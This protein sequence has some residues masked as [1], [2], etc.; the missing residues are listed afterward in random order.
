MVF[1]GF[2]F[3]AGFG[4][5]M[6]LG[7]PTW[8]PHPIRWIGRLIAWEENV[9]RRIFPKN[10]QGALWAGRLLVLTVALLSAGTTYGFLKIAGTFSPWLSW[11]LEVW[12][13]YQLLAAKALKSESMKVYDA[14]RENNLDQARYW[15]SR[16]VGRDT[17]CLDG[18][19]VARAAV[20]TVAENTSDG[21]IAP[22]LYMAIGG[23]PLGILYKAINTMDSMVGYKNERYLDFGRSAAILDDWVNYLPARISAMLML[24]AAVLLGFDGRQAWRVYW[25]DRRNHASPNSAHTEAVCA[26]ALRIRLAGDAWYFGKRYPKPTIGD[27]L[28]PVEPEDIVRANRLMYGT[29]FLALALFAGL[30]ILCGQ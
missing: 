23:A 29:A 22:L 2:A 6:I 20:E 11:G 17:A 3:I 1:Q 30:R 8:M 16:I 18:P 25:R 5:D 7:D 21:V 15:V 24:T 26:G 14:L 27:D 19:Q 12:L 28:R 9:L 4:L 13:C 10:R